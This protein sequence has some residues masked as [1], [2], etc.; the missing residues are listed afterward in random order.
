MR[1]AWS[2]LAGVM[3][4]GSLS[5][6]QQRP[7]L[8]ESGRGQRPFDVTKHSVPVEEL[9]GGGPPRDGIP[10]IDHP[11]FVPAAKASF[12]RGGDRVLAVEHNG[13]AKAYPIGILNW[14][15]IVNDDFAGQ[16]VV[17]TWCPLCL[18]GI[19]YD[20]NVN[21]R[22]LTFGVSGKLYKSA[23]VMYDRET[24][25]LW[26]QIMQQAITG[27]L[28]GT[29]LVMIPAQHTTWE[30]WRKGYPQTLVLSPDTGHRR[31]YGL[32]PYQPYWEG[33]EPHFRSAKD[34]EAA[35]N[36]H[37]LRPME[38]V[39]GVKVNGV[40]KAYPFFALKK[41]GARIDDNIGGSTVRVHFDPK[42]ESAWITD[43]K[44]TTLPSVTTFWFAWTDFYPDSFVFTS[45]GST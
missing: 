36:R 31:D 40:H 34:A 19:V 22:T 6:A 16:P 43:A 4:L 42:S 1:T 26:S 17:V 41:R 37:S 33:G 7:V 15:E 25:S 20:P 8:L 21:G 24:E 5:A 23:L 27:P 10:A 29:K 30:D 2:V 13:V 14:H 11:K 28:T 39:L 44:G 12:L 18:S 45:D 9:R 32:N 3:L 38:R 35:R